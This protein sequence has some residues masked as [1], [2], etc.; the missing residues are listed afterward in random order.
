M[1]TLT[2][3]PTSTDPTILCRFMQAIEDLRADPQFDDGDAEKVRSWLAWRVPA[4]EIGRTLKAAGFKVGTTTI[5][6]HRM[7]DCGCRVDS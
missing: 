5:K 7:N 4:S 6:Q 1:G 3:A 2:A